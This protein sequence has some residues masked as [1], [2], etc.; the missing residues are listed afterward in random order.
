MKRRSSQCRIIAGKETTKVEPR[1]DREQADQGT[2]N[3]R[4]E[5]RNDKDE[6]SQDNATIDVIVQDINAC[7]RES[8]VVFVKKVEIVIQPPIENHPE[9]HSYQRSEERR[10]GK[11]CRSR[12]SPYH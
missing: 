4:Q 12:W 9:Y 3:G 11:E 6:V 5:E 7:D 10:V 1:R 8:V 2:R